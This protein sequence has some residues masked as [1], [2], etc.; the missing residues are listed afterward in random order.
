MRR[1]HSPEATEALG[2]ALAPALAE[3]DLLLL[4]GALGA[5][6]TRFAAGLANGLGSRGRVR[7]PSFTLVNE[8][9]GGRLLLFHLDL[10]R[11]DA[12]DTWG[13]GIDEMRERGVLVVEWGERLPE[14]EQAESLHLVF[15]LEDETTRS[16]AARAL[17]RRGTELLRRWQV[18]PRELDHAAPHPRPQPREG[19]AS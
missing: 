18:L 17:G 3:G 2:A 13:L 14:A 11:L 12:P 6:K 16:I 10:Y 8:Y 5:G 4:S 7:S 1:T 19:R 15:T 9:T